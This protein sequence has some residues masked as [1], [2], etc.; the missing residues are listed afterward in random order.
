M[1]RKRRN[2][3]M[4]ALGER[5][6]GITGVVWRRFLLGLAAGLVRMV[7]VIVLVR[8]EVAVV[9]CAGLPGQ[10]PVAPLHLD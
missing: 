2:G 9:V 6:R 5:N 7:G 3:K 4:K 10:W 8:E 1:V